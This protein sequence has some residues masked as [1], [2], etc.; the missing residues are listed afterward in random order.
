M[1]KQQLSGLIKLLGTGFE[2]TVDTVEKIHHSIADEPLDI[3]EKTPV[4]PAATVVKTAHHGISGLIY[5][6]VKLGGKVVFGASS[7]V[8]DLVDDPP[9]GSNT[10]S[11]ARA[12]NTA[13]DPELIT[14]TLHPDSGFG[15][16]RAGDST[17][18]RSDMSEPGFGAGR[19][20]EVK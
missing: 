14:R 5:G 10:A 3:L 8:L 18:E 6:S 7:A 15:S 11:A 2:K 16:D 13:T 4:K 20:D 12:A 19:R 1:D 17:L 9:A